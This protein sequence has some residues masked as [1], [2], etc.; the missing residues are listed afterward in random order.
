LNWYRKR[1]KAKTPSKTEGVFAFIKTLFHFSYRFITYE[2]PKPDFVHDC[3][4]ACDFSAG[5]TAAAR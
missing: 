4:A 3:H 5:A 2:K 1:K